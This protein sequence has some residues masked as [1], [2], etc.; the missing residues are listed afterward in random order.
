LRKLVTLCAATAL[1]ALPATASAETIK[2]K[3]QIVGDDETR[4]SLKVEVNGLGPVEVA[5]FKAKNV[6]TRCDKKPSRLDFTALDPIQVKSDDTFKARLTDND[7]GF[8]RIAGKVKNGGAAT[9]GSLKTNEI[10]S[11]DGSICKTPKQKFKTS[12]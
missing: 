3:G 6:F 4:V 10:K 11:E 9:V 12:A 2:Q 8:L 5:D 7:G 1:L